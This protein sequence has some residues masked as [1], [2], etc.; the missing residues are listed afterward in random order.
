MGLQ[1]PVSPRTILL[2]DFDMGGAQPPEMI[3][4]RPAVVLV[5]RLPRREGLVTVVP[6]SGTESDPRNEYHCRIEF[7]EPLPHPFPQTVWWAK[8]D[9]TAAVSMR[10]LDLFRTARDHTGSRKY[11]TSLKVSEEI[12]ETIKAAVRKGFGFD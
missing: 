5:G 6:L 12:F 10:R 9:M 3:K 11:I 2:C 7:D 4:K 1:F 8:A